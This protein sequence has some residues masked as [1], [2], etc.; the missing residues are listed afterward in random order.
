MIE[1]M[2]LCCQEPFMSN[3]Y[4]PEQQYCSKPECRKASHSAAN[5]KWRASLRRDDPLRESQI[6]RRARQR[7]RMTLCREL[8]DWRKRLA[9][10][11]MLLL[12][13][14]GLLGGRTGGED[15]AETISRCL[16]AGRDLLRTEATLWEAWQ[17]K[18]CP[19]S[20]FSEHELRDMAMATC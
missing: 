2:C 6:K 9:R 15:L 19:G 14:L 10:C 11:Q 13:M 5:R 17:E 18:P 8:S 1:R 7:R 20:G 12:G 3:K 16:D 4:H